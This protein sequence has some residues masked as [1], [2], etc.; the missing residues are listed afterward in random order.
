MPLKSINQDYHLIYSLFLMKGFFFVILVDIVTVSSNFAP[1]QKKKKTQNK[2]AHNAVLFL[3]CKH[4][5]WKSDSYHDSRGVVASAMDYNIFVNQFE[6]QSQYFTF[7]QIFKIK[8]L[9]GFFFCLMA[10]QLL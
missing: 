6:L 8:D 2:H 10:Y 4:I 3:K 7:E 5:V 1:R 9:L